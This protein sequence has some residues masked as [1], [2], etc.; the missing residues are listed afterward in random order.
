M[1]RKQ[2]YLQKRLKELC[3]LIDEYMSL[4]DDVSLN[5]FL[6]EKE[7][8]Q[9]QFERYLETIKKG[10]PSKHREF[11]IFENSSTWLIIF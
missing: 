1:S 10:N 8:N 7:I 11:K 3:D 2:E 9:I 5:D 4:G 6:K